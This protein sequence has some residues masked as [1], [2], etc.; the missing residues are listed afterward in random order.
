MPGPGSVAAPKIPPGK[1]SLREER[2]LKRLMRRR[3][4]KG[5]TA[6][7]R[8]VKSRKVQ[9]AER[10]V[11][12]EAKLLDGWRCRF[13]ECEVPKGTF[14]GQIDA[15][16]FKAEGSGGDPNLV[17]CTLENLAAVCR[18]HHRGPRSMHS[19]HV[20][21]VPLTSAGARGPV[22][23]QVL[24]DTNDSGKWRSAG[25]TAPPPPEALTLDEDE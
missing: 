4:K 3:G 10:A 6:K 24:D 15:A 16:H 23:W 19:G 22:D 17:R 9:L 11:K 5:T 7:K 1:L 21:P 25:I 8:A 2:E 20:K 18:W 13:P 12:T 14:W